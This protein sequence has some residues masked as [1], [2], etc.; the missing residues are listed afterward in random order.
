MIVLMVI[1]FLS[2]FICVIIWIISLAQF[3]SH[4]KNYDQDTYMHLGKPSMI[5]N[6]NMFT[7]F[8]L[9]KYLV[10]KEFL[11]CNDQVTKSKAIF[12]RIIFFLTIIL[13]I[14]GNIIKILN[15]AK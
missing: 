15:S 5:T 6:N 7:V 8:K 10:N 9:I 1:A 14:I 13:M 4:I 11:N 2:V 12:L 3:F